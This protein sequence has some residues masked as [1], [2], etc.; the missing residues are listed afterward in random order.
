MKKLNKLFVV[1]S[2][3]FLGSSVISCSTNTSKTIKVCASELPHANILNN[4]VKDLI[5]DK[6]YILEVTILDWTMQNDA[7]K[8]GDYDANYFEH[9]PYLLEYSQNKKQEILF[10]SAKVHYEPL[11]I[12]AGKASKGLYDKL[13]TFEICND[14]SN[15]TRALELLV[16]EKIIDSYEKDTDGNAN[17]DKLPSNIKTISENLL[18]SSLPD[19]DYGLLPCNTAMTGNIDATSDKNKNLPSESSELADAKANV[20]TASTNKYKN[21]TDYKTKIDILTDA[22][23]SSSVKDYITKT[24]NSVVLPYQKDLR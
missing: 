11:R 7:V 8:N 21:D 3:L 9:I 1:G 5:K 4:V 22:I 17:L 12:Y 13:A 24:W 2:A 23:L 20:I 16:A 18:V 19:Y 15:A 6:G 10:A 14:V